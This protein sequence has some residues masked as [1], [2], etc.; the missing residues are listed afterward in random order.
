MDETV[1]EGVETSIAD[2]LESDLD[3]IAASKPRG[4]DYI[5][6]DN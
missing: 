6:Q 3:P 4:S 1:D 2:E 5:E